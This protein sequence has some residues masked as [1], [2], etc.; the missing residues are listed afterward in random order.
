MHRPSPSSSAIDALL[1]ERFQSLLHDRDLVLDQSAHGQTF[2]D[3]A[4]FLF[5]EG[6]TVLAEVLEQ[7]IQERI[8]R[9][10][11]TAEGNECPHC[12]R[13][14]PTDTPAPTRSSP[15]PATLPLRVVTAGAA[16][17]RRTLSL[18]T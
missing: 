3:F 7:A 12:K 15:P 2:D 9:T 18:W 17:A 13:K 6:R 10:E 1:V 14:R 11:S 16:M 4:Q 8:K 5:T